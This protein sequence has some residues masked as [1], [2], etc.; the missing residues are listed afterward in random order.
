MII[1]ISMNW[2]ISISMSSFDEQEMRYEDRTSSNSVMPTKKHYDATSNNVKPSFLLSY[3][4]SKRR[5]WSPWNLL[6]LLHLAFSHGGLSAS[7]H[8]LLISSLIILPFCVDFARGLFGE[9]S[10]WEGPPIYIEKRIV[11]FSHLGMRAKSIYLGFQLPRKFVTH[12]YL[13]CGVQ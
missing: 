9:V 7:A 12:W 6:L 11:G 4:T 13:N 1:L 10:Q 8:L 2:S 5:S 3:I